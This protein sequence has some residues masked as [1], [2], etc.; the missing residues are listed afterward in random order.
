VCW[1]ADETSLSCTRTQCS[2]TDIEMGYCTCTTTEAGGNE[3]VGVMTNTNDDDGSASNYCTH[4]SDQYVGNGC[5]VCWPAD[6]TSLSCTR[7]QCSATDIE[8]GYCT[9]TTTEAGF[10]ECTGASFADAQ[11]SGT[12]GAGAYDAS[13]EYA[14]LYNNGAGTGVSYDQDMFLATGAVLDV[15]VCEGAAG[16]QCTGQANED[17]SAST[18]THAADQAT[19]NQA[20]ADTSSNVDDNYN[21]IYYCATF[22]DYYSST[23]T[24]CTYAEANAAANWCDMPL[25][26]DS[27]KTN[28]FCKCKGKKK[29]GN[30]RC[31]DPSSQ[32][33][34]LKS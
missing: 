31:W 19:M 7:T 33:D 27:D 25:C 1:P 30:K 8:M 21:V 24:L 20:L 17:N 32:T 2:A 9:C 23:C 3:C 26:T 6:E 16:M 14:Y 22:G 11:S 5:T 18:G 15:P 4:F 28:K 13:P 10:T 29:N 12:Y 34:P